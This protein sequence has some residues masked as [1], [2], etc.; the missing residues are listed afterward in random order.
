MSVAQTTRPDPSAGGAASPP[1]SM[2][3]RM[4]IIMD[5]FDD[6]SLRLTL[7]ELA[8]RTGLPRSTTHRILNQLVDL[9]WVERG[10]RGYTLGPRALGL[11]GGTAPSADVEI[12]HA[13]AP[14]IHELQVRTGLVVHLSMLEG[15]DIVYLDKLGGRA[16][17]NVPSRVGERAPAH[18][19]A[20]GK[21]ILSLMD[22]EQLAPLLRGRLHRRTP[23]TICDPAT[24]RHELARIRQRGGLAFE[25]GESVP[26][27]GCVA[28]AV[29]GPDGPIAAISLCGEAGLPQLEVLPPL[30]LHAARETSRSLHPSSRETDASRAP[31][32][33]ER[34]SPETLDRMLASAQNG[35][36]I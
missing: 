29:S 33:S 36:W 10:T 6:R 21:A 31:A 25:Q 18:T 2:V 34:W 22:E 8:A 23:R 16:A 24:L 11:G 30:V 20:G 17:A 3:E 27:V 12:R 26:G 9:G 28:A 13:A 4:T 19:T 15:G 7:E 32:P 35:D 14:H 1:T 5:A